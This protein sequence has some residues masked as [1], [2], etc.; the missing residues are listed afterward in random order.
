VLHLCI[1]SASAKEQNEDFPDARSLL[2][3]V[4]VKQVVVKPVV[5]VVE[6][7]SVEVVAAQRLSLE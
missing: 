7:V 4:I 1:I 5:V 3:A 2:L 6:A